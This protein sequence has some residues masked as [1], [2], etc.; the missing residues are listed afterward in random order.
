VNPQ[1]ETKLA[2]Y[3]KHLG[4]WAATLATFLYTELSVQWP[5]DSHQWTLLLLKL[6]PIALGVGVSI[7]GANRTV[8]K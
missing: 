1:Y 2:Y 7:Q 5:A 8:I 3:G 6:V 4:T